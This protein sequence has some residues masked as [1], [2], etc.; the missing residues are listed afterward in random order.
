M[1][2][3]AHRA[4]VVRLPADVT[5]PEYASFYQGICSLLDIAGMLD[6]AT[7]IKDDRVTD[8]DLNAAFDRYKKEYRWGD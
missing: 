3:R 8:T 5:N 4:I 6:E 7:V 2:S 1:D